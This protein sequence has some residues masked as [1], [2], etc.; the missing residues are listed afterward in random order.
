[1]EQPAA[2]LGRQ[3]IAD[4]HAQAT[5]ALH[6]PNARRQFRAEQ[7][8]IGGLVRE[9]PHRREAKVNRRWRVGAQF[10]VDAI[11]E[12]DRAIERQSRFGTDELVDG[13]VIDPLAADRRQV[14]EDG[15]L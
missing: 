7:A 9:A 10:E 15:H 1:V 11:P 14:V 4:T 8:R 3:P 6:P 5:H 12:Y 2:L 13:V